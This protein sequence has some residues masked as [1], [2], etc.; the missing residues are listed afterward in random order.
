MS[1][2]V[3]K[4]RQEDNSKDNHF[5]NNKMPV[6]TEES[7]PVVK[8]QVVTEKKP[9]IDENVIIKTIPN[10]PHFLHEKRKTGKV[11]IKKGTRSKQDVEMQAA[12]TA[13]EK[14][15]KVALDDEKAREKESVKSTSHKEEVVIVEKETNKKDAATNQGEDRIQTGVNTKKLAAKGKK[16]ST[17]DKS[18]IRKERTKKRTTGSGNKTTRKL[19]DA[20]KTDPKQSTITQHFQVRRSERKP[21][22]QKEREARVAVEERILNADESH[23]EI[24]VIE[25]KGRGVFSKNPLKRGDLVC[26]YAGNLISYD[27]ARELEKQYAENPEIGCYMY[28]FVYEEKKYCVDA[29]HESGRLGRLLNHSKTSANVNTRLFPIKGKPYLILV[30]SQDIAPEE[31][32]LYDYGDRSKTAIQSHPWLRS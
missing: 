17:N 25:G 13:E 23:L 27:D 14:I 4:L 5:K 7:V 1:S 28:Y 3:D 26:E 2:T 22:K 31:E 6:P 16:T 30:A 18:P 9:A 8:E 11:T 19:H 29:T 12:K 21:K 24:R 20:E 15:E 32:L 10:K